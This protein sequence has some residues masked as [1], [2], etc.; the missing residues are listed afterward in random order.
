MIL[1]YSPS[2]NRD[3]DLTRASSAERD[4]LRRDME[5]PGIF[6]A[7]GIRR[8]IEAAVAAPIQHVPI[9]GLPYP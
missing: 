3:I 7:P 4:A 6:A 1:V 9:C 2:M 8:V 5:R